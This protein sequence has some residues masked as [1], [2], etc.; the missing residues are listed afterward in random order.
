MDVL[1]LR[2]LAHFVSVFLGN[3][4]ERLPPDGRGLY[5]KS[6]S[7]FMHKNLICERGFFEVLSLSKTGS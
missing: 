7:T 5:L 4:F 1:L 6:R 2:R 3:R